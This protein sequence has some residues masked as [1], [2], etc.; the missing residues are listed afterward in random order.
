MPAS[1]EFF[2][3]H[4]NPVF[5]ETG[6][7]LG[8]GVTA[9]LAAGF[10]VIRSVELSDELFAKNVR[11]FADRPSV[12]IY[13]GS[14]DDQLWN[15][16]ADIDRPITFWLDAH[17]SGGITVKG[18]ENSPILKELAVIA[19]HPIKTHAIL[20]DDRRQ[21]G[22]VDFDFVTEEQIQ[23][24]IRAINPAYQF[25]YETGNTT[26]PMFLNDIIVAKIG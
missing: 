8:E 1:L 22:T 23:N 25:S 13:H 16:I 4:L 7:Y 24:A 6:T 2:T 20:I 17:Y 15:M 9:A 18:S 12:K 26:H 21:V 14:S 11:R 19:R 5:I 3:R 10:P